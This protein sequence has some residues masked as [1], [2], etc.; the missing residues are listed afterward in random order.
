M[1]YPTRR[2][3]RA[4][5]DEAPT[6]LIAH[7][8]Q[9]HQRGHYLATDGSYRPDGGGLGVLIEDA[10]GRTVRRLALPD[11][12]PDN[13]AAEVRALAVGLATLAD[14]CGPDARVG[15]IVDHDALAAAVNGQLLGRPP[16]THLS[17]AQARRIAS[18]RHW[19]AICGHLGRFAALR[20]STVPSAVNPA[21]PLANDPAAYAHL[22]TRP[23]AG[24]PPPGPSATP[25]PSRLAASD[26]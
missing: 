1:A 18:D 21:H 15:V 5:F 17:A 16:A 20:V 10:A 13:N 19:R 3:L 7:P 23:P 25:P 26:D 6:P 9:T 12:P 24:A 22:R 8:P 11:A 14:C 4:L 2:P